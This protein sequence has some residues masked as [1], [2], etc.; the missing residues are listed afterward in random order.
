MKYLLPILFALLSVNGASA[1]SGDAVFYLELDTLGGGIRAGQEYD[2]Y[3]KSTV[4]F[5]SISPP[6]FDERIEVVKG[7]L[8]WRGSSITFEN[9][10]RQTRSGEGISFRIRF[11][12]EGMVELPTAGIRQG[13]REYLTP[14]TVVR[15]LPAVGGGQEVACR[16]EMQPERPGAGE[17]F[18][19]TLTCPVRPDSKEP[20]IGAPGLDCRPIGSGTQV[21]NGAAQ[22]TFTFLARAERAG[23]Y[24]LRAEN[25]SFGGKPCPLEHNFRV[26]HIRAEWI[27]RNGPMLAIVAAL[28][29]ETM[30][31]RVVLHRERKADFAG[32]VLRRKRIPLT[33]S[34]AMTH[35][36]IPLFLVN[37]PV[38]FWIADLSL[39]HPAARSGNFCP[40]FWIGVFPL[41][42]AA[43]LIRRQYR[44]L[45][46]VPVRTA[47]QPA[48]LCKALEQLCREVDWNPDYAG[49][50]CF[51]GHT[52]VR[53]LSWGEQFFVVFDR[54]QAWINSVGNLDSGPSVS[55]FGHVRRD[56][57][58]LQGTI[59]QAR[60]AGD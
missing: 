14:E 1:Q 2:L 10:R 29:L 53:G 23:D 32:F 47:L 9:G 5:D 42:P 57:L 12:R 18:R 20:K 31:L 15:V 27:H 58:L 33:V 19:I 48:D 25:L 54:G 51:A 13:G 11:A 36:G 56:K 16:I 59:E 45:F 6:A 28:L 46:F 22:Y 40:E 8:P 41:I 30:F 55:S 4:P 21:R 38:F 60:P 24:T 35:Y 50:D 52:P 17:D 26:G 34:Q 3:Y 37:I 44:K 49:E 7:P 39:Q 43:W